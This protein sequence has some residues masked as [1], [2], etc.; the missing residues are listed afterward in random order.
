MTDVLVILPV[1]V[2]LVTAAL[3]MAAWKHLPTQRVVGVA[4][5]AVGLAA[6]TA[7]G[8]WVF[9][10]GPVSTAAGG[11]P[12]PFGITLVAD[13]LAVVMVVVSALMGFAVAVY[14]V[15]EV[16]EVRQ[17]DTFWPLFHVLLM[18]VQGAFLTGD[19]FNLYV[20][21]E[22]MLMASFVLLA[23]GGDRPQM[24][25]ALTYVALNL[26]SS[27]LFLAAVGLVYAKAHTLNLADLSVRM[28][29]VAAQEP[30]LVAAVAGLFLVA[31]GIKAGLF[32]LYAW[33]P[34][35]Y[36]TP[37]VAVSAI[38]AGLLTKVGVYALL[39]VMPL[40]FGTV[41]AVF[42]I[43]LWAACLT[44]IA[45]VL[46]A[47][48]QFNV[49]RV[50][51]F[52]IISQIGYM[53]LGLALI[54]SPDAGVRRLALAAMVFYIAHHIVVKT[55]LFL[56]A[57][58]IRRLSGS[59]ELKG[60]GGLASA[61][62]WLAALFLIPALSLAGIPPLSGFWAKL[63]VVRAGL[64]ASLW[65]AVAAALVAGL[66]TLVSMVKIWNEAFWKAAPEDRVPLGIAPWPLV[67]PVAALAL[68]TVVIGLWPEVLMR[69]ATS[70][71][72]GVLDPA[73]YRAA[74]GLVTGT[75][76]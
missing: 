62:P 37:P 11:W 51:S 68:I 63:A 60:I 76:G 64:D 18:G 57:G 39:R 4:G 35:S 5:A 55:N 31:F 13:P 38:F 41:P 40:V 14:A 75:G 73:A 10:V 70:A 74:V 49:R 30:T 34:A 54:A 45:G 17:R 12:P 6:A 3:A 52:H 1:L 65:W 9:T 58:L 26:L 33:L 32:P 50:L 71:A 56:I 22:V 25:G 8:W 19:L 48:A 66:L 7:L 61:A 69:I 44:M 47:V 21:F 43:L 23:L 24:E 27:A 29:L 46:G 36:H 72:D 42:T 16:D 67:A 53:V 28:P 2:P 15:A 20:C 59:E